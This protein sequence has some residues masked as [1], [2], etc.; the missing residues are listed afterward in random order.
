MNKSVHPPY[1]GRKI[2]LNKNMKSKMKNYLQFVFHVLVQIIL[3]FEVLVQ[4]MLDI[5]RHIMVVLH[6][7][8][9]RVFI[10]IILD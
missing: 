7:L 5:S 6:L 8:I 9:G 1:F 2:N 3:A 4:L 10:L